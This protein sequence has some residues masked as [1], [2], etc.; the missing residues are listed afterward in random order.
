MYP[1]EMEEKKKVAKSIQ[2]TFKRIIM[3]QQQIFLITTST[4][5]IT[6]S[7]FMRAH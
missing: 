7:N 6:C 3:Q 2:I 5:F 4:S 1:K